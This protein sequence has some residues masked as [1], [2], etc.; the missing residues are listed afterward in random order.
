MGQTLVSKRVAQLNELFEDGRLTVDEGRLNNK[1]EAILVQ[2]T[3][4][5]SDSAMKAQASLIDS[6][7]AAMLALDIQELYRLSEETKTVAGTFSGDDAD[8]LNKVSAFLYDIA[9]YQSTY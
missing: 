3:Y 5:L 2:V 8:T 6:I 4:H 7:K 9:Y 1:D